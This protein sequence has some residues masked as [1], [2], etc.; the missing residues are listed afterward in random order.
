MKKHIVLLTLMLASN[1]ANAWI[2]FEGFD[3]LF[4]NE[5]ARK[6]VIRNFMFNTFHGGSAKAW[7]PIGEDG[8]Y[9]TEAPTSTSSLRKA[10][11]NSSLAYQF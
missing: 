9:S 5:F 6:L 3:G 11:V 8:T 2:L 4:L 7:A 1:A 10:S